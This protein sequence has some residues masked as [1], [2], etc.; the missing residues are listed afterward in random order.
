M[1]RK[2]PRNILD[3]WEYWKK[4]IQYWQQSGLSQAEFCRQN[5]LT[6]Q[7]LSKW[8]RKLHDGQGP[9]SATQAKKTKLSR[10]RSNSNRFVEVRLTDHSLSS[11]H[12][13][14]VNGRSLQVG[15]T[16]DARIISELITIMERTC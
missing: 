1:A 12:I 11:Y 14:L 3:R 13:K 2:L 16:Y 8:K 4:Q 10:T 7:Q 6:T 5:G 15:N 9:E